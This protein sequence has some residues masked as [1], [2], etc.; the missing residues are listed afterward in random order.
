MRFTIGFAVFKLVQTSFSQFMMGT[1]R[2]NFVLLSSVIG[3]TCNALAAYVMLFGK[4]GVHPMGIVGAALAQCIGTFIE[5]ATLIVFSLCI[6]ADRIKFNAL[7][8]KFRP[9]EMIKLVRVGFGS[10]LQFIVEVL[11]WSLFANLA[12]GA[13]GETA[14]AANAFMFR[15]LVCTFLPALGISSAVTALVGRYIGMGRPDLAIKRAHLGFKVALVWLVICG[16]AFITFRRSLI[17]LFT[18]DPE[19]IRLGAILMIFAACY[20]LFDG[21]YIVYYGAL[22]GAGDT[23][24]PAI[25]TAGFCWSIMLGGGVMMAKYFPKLSVAG[26]W[27]I[28][29]VYGVI[30]GYF[31]VARFRR[32][33][34]RAIHLEAAPNANTLVSTMVNQQELAVSEI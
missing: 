19:I 4:L 32:G 25:A 22:R 14:M 16:I 33:K 2:P 3:V 24:W 20:E 5:M 11:A 30:L 1:N 23:F 18:T 17:G 12:I 9:N 8:M 26:P 7:D 15:Y 10:G 21:M 29:S 27:G 6:R 31:M 28:A 13:L 34:W